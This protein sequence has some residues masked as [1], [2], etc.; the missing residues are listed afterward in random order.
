LL[1][2]F[3]LT[4]PASP[5]VRS[6]F[7]IDADNQHRPRIL[8]VAAHP[9]DETIGAGALLSRNKHISILHATDGAPLEM[10]DA[11]SAGF[12]SRGAYGSARIAEARE[13]LG[14]AGVEA[15][16]VFNMRLI[17]QRLS[18]CL[19]E[20]TARIVETLTR[21]AP[22]I[23][24]THAYEG[25]HPDHDSVAFA[26]HTAHEICSN[27]Q[28]RP[29]PRLMEFA[30]YHGENGSIKTHEFLFAMGAQE[31]QHRL[32][33]NEQ[34]LKTLMLTTFRTQAKTLQP[35]LPPQIEKYRYAPKY[36]FYR[37][38]HSGKLFYE[39]FDWGMDGATWRRLAQNALAE[40][41]LLRR[42]SCGA[43]PS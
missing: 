6:E 40:L 5:S 11:L 22:D 37:P 28:R 42:K 23:V 33:L 39:H 15:S 35:F 29:A 13:A 43:S 18:F 9:D 16:N 30:G 24:L 32:T 34:N 21:E 20:L 14:L 10:S 2:R 31:I 19:A 12:S 7:V 36:D 27:S 8:L 1:T 38:P 3:C 26:C 4:F 17:D 25:G 41:N